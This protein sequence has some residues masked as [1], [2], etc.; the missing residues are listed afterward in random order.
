[1]KYLWL[2]FLVTLMVGQ[3]QLQVKVSTTQHEAKLSWKASNQKVNYR[4]WR[5]TTQTGKY[6]EIKSGITVLTYTDTTVV[7]GDTYYYKV[8]CRNPQT[9]AT[10]GYS[11]I[12]KAV[13]P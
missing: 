2:I 12:V 9:N 6:T 1:M 3:E 10:S 7:G 4:V 5:S 13:I 8:D 11:N